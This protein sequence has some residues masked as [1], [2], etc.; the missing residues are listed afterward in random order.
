MFLFYGRLLQYQCIYSIEL[1]LNLTQTHIHLYGSKLL[2]QRRINVC[3][4]MQPQ[5]R[6]VISIYELYILILTSAATNARPE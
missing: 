6:T 2:Q 5:H 1:Y 3:N 4:T